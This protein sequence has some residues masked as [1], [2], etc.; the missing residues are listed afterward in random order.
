MNMGLLSRLFGGSQPKQVQPPV[1]NAIGVEPS[2]AEKRFANKLIW[3]FCKD[4][5]QGCGQ[6][7]GYLPNQLVW[8]ID[9]VNGTRWFVLSLDSNLFNPHCMPDNLEVYRYTYPKY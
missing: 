5:D 4:S 9:V 6:G 1:W 2:E 8:R 7:F 3:D